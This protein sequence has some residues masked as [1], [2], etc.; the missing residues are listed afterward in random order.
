MTDDGTSTLDAEFDRK[1]EAER[2]RWLRRRF[3]WF[4][5]VV[6]VLNLMAAPFVLVPGIIEMMVGAPGP[7]PAYPIWI[8]RAELLAG[9]ALVV[10]AFLYVLLRPPR[11]PAMLR[12]AEVVTA[13]GGALGL[14]TQWAESSLLGQFDVHAWAGTASALILVNHL[15]ACLFLPWTPRECLRPGLALVALHALAMAAGVRRGDDAVFAVGAV[16]LSPLLLTPGLFVCWSRHGRFRNR[17]RLLVESEG[18]RR[19][20]GELASARR[21]HESCMPA[22]LRDGPV[23]LEYAYAPMQQIGGDLLFVPPACAA[24]GAGGSASCCSTSPATAWPRR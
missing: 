20:H 24:A 3:L 12:L 9:L 16:V 23:C 4:C 17:F 21:I 2:A 14:V 11:R 8:A 10:G 19:L 18:Y 1:L 7:P 5:G 13:G 15:P 6:G 22:P